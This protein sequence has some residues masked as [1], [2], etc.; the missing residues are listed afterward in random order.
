MPNPRV[1]WYHELHRLRRI[2]SDDGRALQVCAVTTVRWHGLGQKPGKLKPL[3]A[4][5]RVA[6]SL[7][8]EY[9]GFV[10]Q[11]SEVKAFIR[12]VP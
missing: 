9:G 1:W 11:V 8:L 10:E 12:V 7:E 4:M 5:L 3:D 2:I 6:E